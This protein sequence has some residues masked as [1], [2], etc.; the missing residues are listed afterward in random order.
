MTRYPKAGKGGEWK[1]KELQVIP[2]DWKGDTISD[3]G[4]LSGEVRVKA[5]GYQHP[6]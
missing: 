3:G 2:A 1:V 5:D 4:G 6:L